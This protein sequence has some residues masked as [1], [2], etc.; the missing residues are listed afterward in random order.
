[1]PATYN[2]D[3]PY[4][5][6]D[7]PLSQLLVAAISRTL[8]SDALATSILARLEARYGSS[9][10]HFLVYC[11]ARAAPRLAPLIESQ[12]ARLF[13]AGP[14]GCLYRMNAAPW[15]RPD[16]FLSRQIETTGPG[17]STLPGR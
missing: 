1:M 6:F 15:R 16:Q 9:S 13:E 4:A 17:R 7:F 12:G 2:L 8:G 5:V 3:M 11:P 14:S 10:G